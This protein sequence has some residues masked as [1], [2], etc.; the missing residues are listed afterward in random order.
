MTEKSDEPIQVSEFFAEA[1]VAPIQLQQTC[2]AV[3][4][5]LRPGRWTIRVSN[6][7]NDDAQ[8]SL[9]GSTIRIEQGNVYLVRSVKI[10]Q[11]ETY[12]CSILEGQVL[13]DIWPCDE[14]VK[15]PDT[16]RDILLV[17]MGACI[18]GAIVSGLYMLL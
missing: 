9:F 11:L 10:D 1:V 3:K 14:E 15:Q 8:V 4:V 17:S 16:R 5:C 6:T 18:T 7:G 2:P 13:L 12:D